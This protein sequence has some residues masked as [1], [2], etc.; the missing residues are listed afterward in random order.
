[1][2]LLKAATRAHPH[3]FAWQAGNATKNS[4]IKRIMGEWKV[5][6]VSR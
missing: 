2:L 5:G 6:C 3:C 1:M 4:A